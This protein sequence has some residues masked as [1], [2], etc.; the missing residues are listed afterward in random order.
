MKFRLVF[1]AAFPPTRC[2][3]YRDGTIASK[4]RQK[5]KRREESG[6]TLHQK[7][8]RT[9]P[10]VSMRSRPERA[11]HRPFQSW[12]CVYRYQCSAVQCSAVWTRNLGHGLSAFDLSTSHAHV[13]IAMRHGHAY[14]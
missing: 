1:S 5:A 14:S 6:S 13:Y 9:V 11:L 3:V 2:S 10:D 7:I 8:P 12:Y 4:S